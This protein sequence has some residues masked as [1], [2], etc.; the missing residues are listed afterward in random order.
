MKEKSTSVEYTREELD[1]L[2]DETD[3]A[4][5]DAITDEEVHRYA[6]SDPDAQPTDKDFWQSAKPPKTFM[7]VEPD[8]LEWFKV[9]SSGYEAQINAVLRA[10]IESQT[11]HR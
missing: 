4:R 5:V 6:L 10:Y 11:A 3:W 8:I 9:R 7:S 2:P 1:A